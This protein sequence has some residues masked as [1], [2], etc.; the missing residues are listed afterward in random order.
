MAPLIVSLV[1]WV[2]LAFLVAVAARWRGRNFAGWFFAA[3]LFSPLL[4]MLTLLIL[5]D[6]RHEQ[7][8]I[9]T[10]QT[11]AGAFRVLALVSLGL[12]AL[13]MVPPILV[14]LLPS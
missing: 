10:M 3:V 13:L 8:R 6:L 11:P 5:R 1:A 9:W 2:V 7:R 14:S 4:A 12:V